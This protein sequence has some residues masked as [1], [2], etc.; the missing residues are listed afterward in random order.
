MIVG[1]FGDSSRRAIAKKTWQ[2]NRI[3]ELSCLKFKSGKRSF[4]YETKR[5]KPKPGSIQ[6]QLKLEPQMKTTPARQHNNPKK[7]TL[8]VLRL[9]YIH[10]HQSLM[11]RL[12]S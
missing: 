7:Q 10:E 11:L 12:Q 2:K 8:T 6:N 5:R 9:Q 1:R 3:L 4:F